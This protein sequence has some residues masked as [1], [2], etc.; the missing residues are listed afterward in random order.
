MIR[1]YATCTSCG[2]DAALTETVR[3]AALNLLDALGWWDLDTTPLCPNCAA[4]PSI[5]GAVA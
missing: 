1:V 5:T 4:G 3:D 2:Q